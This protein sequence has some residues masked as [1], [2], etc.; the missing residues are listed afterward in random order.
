MQTSA[1]S[2]KSS[3]GCQACFICRTPPDVRFFSNR[4]GLRLSSAGL[5][6][7][8]T[9]ALRNISNLM[10]SPALISFRGQAVVSRKRQYATCARYATCALARERRYFLRARNASS[11]A[12]R[13]S[14]SGACAPPP[15]P[16]P[17]PLLQSSSNSRHPIRATPIRTNCTRW[18]GCGWLRLVQAVGCGKRLVASCG[19]AWRA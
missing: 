17:P 13:P 12:S 5:A 18:L 15:P 14:V 4:A 19:R 6:A 16:P 9:C 10:E 1:P 7:C 11:A 3:A 2:L 8:A